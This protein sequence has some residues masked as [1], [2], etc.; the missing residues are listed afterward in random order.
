MDTSTDTAI[1]M[2]NQACQT[3]LTFVVHSPYKFKSILLADVRHAVANDHSYAA[4]LNDFSV[5]P[6]EQVPKVS[7]KDFPNSK[8]SLDFS[9]IHSSDFPQVDCQEEEIEDEWIPS[10]VSDHEES[11]MSDLSDYEEN[12][13]LTPKTRISTKKLKFLTITRSMNP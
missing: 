3:D 4:F 7:G 2:V 6:A 5:V 13:S 8:R 12:E 11:D 10:D 9:K 1:T